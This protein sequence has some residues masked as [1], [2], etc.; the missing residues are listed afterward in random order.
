M[1]GT[2]ESAHLQ[3]Q[4]VHRM[5]KYSNILTQTTIKLKA[6]QSGLS[7]IYAAGICM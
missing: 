6:E 3:P 1:L 7:P 5:T 2:A 4:E